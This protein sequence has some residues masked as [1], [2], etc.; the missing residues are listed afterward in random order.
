M[1]HW[2]IGGI[3]QFHVAV[4]WNLYFQLVRPEIDTSTNLRNC[5]NEL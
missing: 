2:L 3:S 5:F 4:I 1:Y